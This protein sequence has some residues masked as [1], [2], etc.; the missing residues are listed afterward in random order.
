MVLR[1][2]YVEDHQC[3]SKPGLTGEPGP[4]GDVGPRGLEGPTVVSGDPGNILRLG[5]DHFLMLDPEELCAAGFIR[6]GSDSA[7][8]IVTKVGCSLE[9]NVKRSPDGGNQLEIRNNGLFV[10]SSGGGGAVTVYPVVNSLGVAYP[11]NIAGS[12]IIDTFAN[13]P[14]FTGDVC[15]PDVNVNSLGSNATVFVFSDRYPNGIKV[16]MPDLINLVNGCV[17]GVPNFT[18]ST[19]VLVSNGPFTLNDTVTWTIN[20]TNSG[21]VAAD[22]VNVYDQVPSGFDNIQWSAPGS[23]TPTGSGNVDTTFVSIGSGETKTITVSAVAV[24]NGVY[25]NSV[26]IDGNINIDAAAVLISVGYNPLAVPYHIAGADSV[27][28]PAT[29]AIASTSNGTVTASPGTLA[30]VIAGLTGSQR[31]ELAPGS[32]SGTFVLP[33]AAAG[34]VITSGSGGGVTLGS[35]GAATLFQLD[36]SQTSNVT[37]MNVTVGRTTNFKPIIINKAG[38]STVGGGVGHRIHN[39]HFLNAGGGGAAD[40]NGVIFVGNPAEG[41]TWPFNISLYSSASNPN[42]NTGGTT[43][44]GAAAATV[45]NVYQGSDGSYWSY[46]GSAYVLNNELMM[47]WQTREGEPAWTAN[48]LVDECL[49]ENQQS[50]GVWVTTGTKNV[51]VQK[52]VWRGLIGLPTTGEG[53]QVKFG[54]GW[55]E[56]FPTNNKALYNTLEASC[57]VYNNETTGVAISGET[58]PYWLGVK[59]STVTVEG[60]LI[61][62]SRLRTSIR[63]GVNCTVTKNVSVDGDLRVFGTGHTI[64]YNW[65]RVIHPKDNVAPLSLG[66][67]SAPYTAT[68]LGHTLVY[69]GSGANHP[70]YTQAANGALITNNVFIAAGATSGELS[71]GSIASDAFVAASPGIDPTA[72]VVTDNLFA[73][74]GYGGS[75]DLYSSTTG[76]A[77]GAAAMGTWTDNHWVILS[78]ATTVASSQSAL[79]VSFIGTNGNVNNALLLEADAPHSACP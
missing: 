49:F 48:L 13:P 52:N 63:A 9:A 70:Y 39:V 67:Q 21:P 25:T 27:C 79:N 51:T 17:S 61:L 37:L 10:G 5:S 58:V 60:N 15:L 73:R 42:P 54:S 77:A 69:D 72:I 36:L 19:K 56:A 3:E 46:N 2:S 8:V 33:T 47:R 45:G 31:L 78:D 62:A 24:A 38:N 41:L 40:S 75:N 23:L 7:S 76:S 43:F 66:R 35:L 29:P 59:Q 32:Y 20:V 28:A 11:T 18:T 71:V 68:Y 4:K 14:L 50:G 74:I 65:F 53:E 6:E 26:L 30:T 1:R 57:T 34:T 22:F 55:A 44:T 16:A 12:Q 64:T